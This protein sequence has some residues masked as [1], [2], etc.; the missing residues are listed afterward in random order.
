MRTLQKRPLADRYVRDLPCR[1]SISHPRGPR[2]TAQLGSRRTTSWLHASHITDNYTSRP[3]GDNL[4]TAGGVSSISLLYFSTPTNML[5]IFIIKSGAAWQDCAARNLHPL[6]G[7]CYSKTDTEG[8]AMVWYDMIYAIAMPQAMSK[9]RREP[10][11][12]LDPGLDSAPSRYLI[13]PRTRFHLLSRFCSLD[14]R[15]FAITVQSQH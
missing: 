10:R 9:H 8:I 5:S 12:V 4:P 13:G 14:L 1:T 15:S 11:G 3:S 2:L 6:A 7:V